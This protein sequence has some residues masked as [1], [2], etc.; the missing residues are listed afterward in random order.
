MDNNLKCVYFEKLE[1]KKKKLRFITAEVSSVITGFHYMSRQAVWKETPG[2]IVSLRGDCDN[3][4][5]LLQNRSIHGSMVH[6]NAI[7]AYSNA[8]QAWPYTIYT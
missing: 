2:H 5:Y 3:D 6:A 8:I 7:Q 1:K 4:N